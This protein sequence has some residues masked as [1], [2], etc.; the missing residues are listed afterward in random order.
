MRLVHLVLDANDPLRL[1][2]FWSAALGWELEEDPDEYAVLPAG[3]SYPDPAAVPIVFVPVPEP[4]A[5]KNRLHLELATESTEQQRAEVGRLLA[6]GAV[7]VDIGQGDDATWVV[8]ADP[9]GNE[10]C[11]LAPDGDDY[12]ETGRFSGVVAD[13]ADP[14]KVAD[15]WQLATGW[16]RIEEAADA[17]TFRSPAGSGPF[18]T[19]L[20]TPNQK[21]TN[22][23]GTGQKATK[24][25][26]HLD[27]AP[28]SGEDQAQAVQLLL[29]AGAVFADVGQGTGKT[30]VVLADPEGSE[31]CVLTPR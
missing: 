6:L 31:F 7:R 12:R 17:V 22:Q 15:F 23:K 3:C 5:G 11:V 18:F 27:V 2:R 25:R 28:R 20:R 19:L 10:F 14:A 30:W 24:N 26:M 16:D 21:G 29:D 1:A 9:E 13:C 4:K 8:L